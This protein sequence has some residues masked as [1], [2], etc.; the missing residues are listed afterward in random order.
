MAS[1]DGTVHVFVRDGTA[2]GEVITTFEM[3][4]T[5]FPSLVSI[6]ANFHSLCSVFLEVKL[7]NWNGLS[8]NDLKMF[9]K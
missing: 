5:Y 7:G 1:A 2:T 9:L 3:I 6:P 8:I 4:P